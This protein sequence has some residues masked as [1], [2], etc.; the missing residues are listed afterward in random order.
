[1]AP[2]NLTR[3][4]IE[5]SENSVYAVIGEKKYVI[6]NISDLSPTAEDA[7]V[8]YEDGDD[9]AWVESRAG[10]KVVEDKKTFTRAD[11]ERWV[12]EAVRNAPGA[13]LAAVAITLGM[14]PISYKG[15]DSFEVE[16]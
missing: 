9:K 11:L 14:S 10:T 5:R 3:A 4:R 12:Y 1:M 13:Q 2:S 15:N 16:A 8:S 6:M 7:I